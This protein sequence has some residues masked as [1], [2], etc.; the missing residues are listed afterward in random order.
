MKISFL[1]KKEKK[2]QEGGLSEK[3]IEFKNQEER[4]PIPKAKFTNK[5]NKGGETATEESS[6]PSIGST[7]VKRIDED[8]G[9]DYCIVVPHPDYQEP[10]EDYIRK[11]HMSY[12]EIL[13]RL[14]MAQLETYQFRSGDGDE[15]LIKIRAPLHVLK[16]W[17][18]FKSLVV[19]CNPD[20]LYNVIDSPILE[21]KIAQNSAITSLQPYDH[22]FFEYDEDR[23]QQLYEP[24]LGYNHPFSNRLRIKLINTIIRSASDDAKC[25]GCSLDLDKIMNDKDKIMYDKYSTDNVETFKDNEW[26][27]SILKSYPLHDYAVRDD[28]WTEWS[29]HKFNPWDSPTDEIKV[30]G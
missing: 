29:S 28:L 23:D 9:Y 21:N 18:T 2:G 3:L 6:I 4:K 1:K 11:V 13:D 19:E 7:T 15:V 17:A 10:D 24:A 5:S 16:K 8:Y 20:Y 25:T 27:H 14:H 12:Y 30:R 26:N 22:M